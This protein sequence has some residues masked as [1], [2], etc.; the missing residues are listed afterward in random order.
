MS[1]NQFYHL[2][3]LIL[4]IAYLQRTLND[5]MIF[6]LKCSYIKFKTIKYLG[7]SRVT[8]NGE[9]E[10]FGWILTQILHHS[11]VLFM[12]IFCKTKV[13]Q[14]FINLKVSFEFHLLLLAI[15]EWQ[16]SS[17]K[18]PKNK[19]EAKS[20]RKACWTTSWGFLAVTSNWNATF[21]N[22]LLYFLTAVSIIRTILNIQPVSFRK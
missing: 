21:G 19:N 15:F 5:R 8:L 3:W 10:I 14:Y 7:G 17:Q 4:E 9:K 16:N 1:K 20:R 13:R 22:L 6:I 12:W 11:S 18:K 2:K